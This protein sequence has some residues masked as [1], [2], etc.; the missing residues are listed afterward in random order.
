LVQPVNPFRKETKRVIGD[1]IQDDSIIDFFE[2]IDDILQKYEP[3]K[4]EYKP[5]V[6]KQITESRD[7]KN[8]LIQQQI[9]GQINHLTES[10]RQIQ[11]ISS[12]Q[13]QLIQILMRDNV[14]MKKRISVLENNI[15][16]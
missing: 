5:E 4:V 1:F 10:F 16:K 6:I 7:K 13:N 2:K 3:G 14:E 8:I 15:N 11:K 9:C 12:D